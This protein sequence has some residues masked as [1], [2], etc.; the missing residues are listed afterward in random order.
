MW[1]NHPNGSSNLIRWR[2]PFLSS[3]WCDLRT[4][5]VLTNKIEARQI[6]LEG[7]ERSTLN[8]INRRDRYLDLARECSL[9]GMFVQRRRGWFSF[10]WLADHYSLGIVGEGRILASLHRSNP[11]TVPFPEFQSSYSFKSIITGIGS[12]G[13][14]NFAINMILILEFPKNIFSCIACYGLTNHYCTNLTLFKCSIISLY[15]LSNG[16][17]NK[18]NNTISR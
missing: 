4:H 5:V 2:K 15:T 1:R 9:L 12:F 11:R 6:L 13:N 8:S 14:L 10:D 18:F 3:G 7:Y 16:L 17:K